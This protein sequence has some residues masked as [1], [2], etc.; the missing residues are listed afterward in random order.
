MR[1]ITYLCLADSKERN[2]LETWINKNFEFSFFDSEKNR[3]GK[4]KNYFDIT[5]DSLHS[6]SIENLNKKILHQD[7]RTICMR[8]MSVK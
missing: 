6:N 7:Q 3:N 5:N 4:K 1:A 8:E 2:I